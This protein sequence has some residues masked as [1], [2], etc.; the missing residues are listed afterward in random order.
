[1]P[2]PK[3]TIQRRSLLRNWSSHPAMAPRQAAVHLPGGPWG[4]SSE[5]RGGRMRRSLLEW[6]FSWRGRPLG[7]VWPESGT[8]REPLRPRRA[9]GPWEAEYVAAVAPRFGERRWLAA[10]VAGVRR[11][12]PRVVCGVLI[13]AGREA[14]RLSHVASAFALCHAAYTVALRAGWSAEGAR[15]A[16]ALAALAE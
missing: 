6:P 14:A 15:A 13:G 2:Q 12:A 10:L 1:N 5:P 4:G 3:K 8:G 16:T 7:P 9:L 11:A